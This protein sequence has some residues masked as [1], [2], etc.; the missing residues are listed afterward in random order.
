[1][2]WNMVENNW[3]HFQDL[4]KGRWGKLSGDRLRAIEGKRGQLIG[5]IQ[6]IYGISADAAELQVQDFELRNRDY[7]PWTSSCSKWRAV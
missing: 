2:D 7:R 3:A 6:E 5:K 4:I 1:M